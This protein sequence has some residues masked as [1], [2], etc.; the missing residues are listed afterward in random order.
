MNMKSIEQATPGSKSPSGGNLLQWGTL[1]MCRLRIPSKLIGLVLFL[2]APMLVLLAN[3]LLTRVADLRLVKFEQAGIGVAG[4][5]SVLIQ[6]ALQ[7]GGLSARTLSGDASASSA[8]EVA[9]QEV[10]KGA[11]AVGKRLAE[12]KKYSMADEWKHTQEAVIHL[13]DAT[14]PDL[15]SA[16]AAQADVVQVLQRFMM[17]NAER[18][19][20]LVEAHPE[21]HFLMG[22]AV[23]RNLVSAGDMA[24]LLDQ[25]TT[26]LLSKQASPADRAL[27]MMSARVAAERM[28]RMSDGV[29][30]LARTGGPLPKA[31]ERVQKSALEFLSQ[32]HQAFD[33]EVPNG[34]ALAYFSKGAQVIDAQFELNI[35][36]LKR[37]EVLLQE[38]GTRV[39]LD[40]ILAACGCLA[41]TGLATFLGL[42][43]HTAFQQSMK[44]VIKNMELAGE[45]DFSK[46]VMVTGSDEVALMSSHLEKMVKRLSGMVSEIRSSAVKVGY[47]GQQVADGGNAMAEKTELQ[48]LRLR[49]SMNTVTELTQAVAASAN[50][51]MTLDQMTAALVDRSQ[52]G[53]EA[54]RE[55]L[56]SMVML[57]QSTQRVAEI[58]G[59]IEDLAFQTNILALNAAVEAA[60]AGDAG[61]G[62]AV[63]AGEVRQLAKRCSE[64]AAEIEALIDQTTERVEVTKSSLKDVNLTLTEMT[65]GIGTVSGRLKELA[66]AS[67]DQ[68]CSLHEVIASV[69]VMN[70]M[71]QES[72]VL[73][74]RSS[75]ASRGLLES[76]ATLRKTVDSIQLRQGNSEDARDLVDRAV[77][78][79]H[80]VGMERAFREFADMSGRWVDRGMFLVVFDHEGCY[81]VHP[82]RPDLSG[83][84]M[85]EVFG[86]LGEKF[87]SDAQAASAAGRAW[88][89]FAFPDDKTGQARPQTAYVSV[90]NDDLFIASAADDAAI[91]THGIQLPDLIEAV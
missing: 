4:D 55:T 28:D 13:A 18:S 84:P 60:H 56:E 79:L 30:A 81:R 70:T 65:D 23:E 7:L 72:S 10:K 31:W 59:V 91:G 1:L 66:Q 32:T 17:L 42:C 71:T 20:L 73:V 12:L 75:T 34:D 50:G 87:L 37:L 77:R 46:S 63:V 27:V 89:H 86:T 15:P 83:K 40:M 80:D 88:V 48:G 58:N 82:A 5:V 9:A 24:E 57:E 44:V 68:S 64:A 36:I 2:V 61:K 90:L 54:M 26:L 69:S 67:A 62:F 52:M 78:Y 38:R 21:T 8:K 35:E 76:A 41:G 14:F 16:N 39:L 47:S 43:M 53:S 29:D 19:M 22:L 51:A 49:E 74:E 33:S 6:R 25:A 45:G 3:L 85:Q 11:E